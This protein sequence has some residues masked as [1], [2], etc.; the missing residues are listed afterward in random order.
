MLLWGGSIRWVF[1]NPLHFAI[2]PEVFG[3]ATV[4][5]VSRL[6]WRADKFSATLDTL[7]ILTHGSAASNST[8]VL[9]T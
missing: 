9:A 7:K 6:G 5:V 2:S 4:T 8:K 1:A 3:A